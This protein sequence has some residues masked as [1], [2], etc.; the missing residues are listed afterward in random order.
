[1]L[2]VPLVVRR[3]IHWPLRRCALRV[4]NRHAQADARPAVRSRVENRAKVTYARTRRL[5]EKSP[6]RAN[7]LRQSM[8]TRKR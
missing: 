2:A 1:L 5:R 4:F 3:K 6:A 7:S 8:T